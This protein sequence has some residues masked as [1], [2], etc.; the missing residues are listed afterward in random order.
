MYGTDREIL[1]TAIDW[2]ELGHRVA[3]VTVA[4]TW[5]SSP[6][7]PGSMLVM[8]EDG[9]HAG[10]VSGGCIEED[11]VDRY[12]KRELTERFPNLIN[13]GV[14]RQDA[15]RFGLP[16]GGR[17]EL[18]VEKLESAEPLKTL[19]SRINSGQLIARRVCMN[20]GEVSLHTSSEVNDFRYTDAEM[21]K[22]FGPAWHLLLIG[23]GHLTRYVA[24]IALMLDYN[25]TVCDPR[26]EYRAGWDMEGVNFTHIMP[27]DAVKQII[28]RHRTILITLAHD[29]KLD[30]MALMEA[31]TDDI[32]YVGALGSKRSNDQRRERMRQLGVTEPQ[33][34]RL[35]AP[36]GLPIGSH[37]PPEIAVSIMAEITAVRNNAHQTG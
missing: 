20:T 30:D 18:V 17:L 36:V 15:L 10:S 7:P 33:L 35:H 9:I 26:E 4:K 31:L 16:C 6:R 28:N 19:L 23:A 8:R 34:A 14:N 22:I 29:P 37:T 11:L 12:K 25:V 27:D 13:Y 2:L 21:I 3:L 32:F 5:G 1:Q 24:G